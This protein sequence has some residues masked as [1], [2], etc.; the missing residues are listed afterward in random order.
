MLKSDVPQRSFSHSPD[1]ILFPLVEECDT[2]NP[3]SREKKTNINSSIQIRKRQNGSEVDDI[4]KRAD[5]SIDEEN[6]ENLSDED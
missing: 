5:E 6:F 2:H 4:P 3:D 1:L